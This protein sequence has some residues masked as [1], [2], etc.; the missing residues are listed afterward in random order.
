MKQPRRTCLPALAWLLAVPAWAAVSVSAAPARPVADAPLT[1][2][3]GDD[4]G[5]GPTGPWTFRVASDGSATLTFP[6][7]P[8]SK[9]REFRVSPRQVAELR[10]L[11]ASERFFT[12]GTVYGEAVP[13]SNTRSVKVA[14]GTRSKTV[15]LKYLQRPTPHLAEVKRALRVWRLVRGWFSDPRVADDRPYDRPILDA[16]ERR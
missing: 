3:L 13:D 8:K 6:W 7:S 9:P 10:K 5:F 14:L 2:T 4:G 16:P 1:V 15:T 12:L 11:I